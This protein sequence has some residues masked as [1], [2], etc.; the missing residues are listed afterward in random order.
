MAFF[1]EKKKHI[2]LRLN[3]REKNRMQQTNHNWN[4]GNGKI[5]VVFAC[6]S[7][8]CHVLNDNECI[9][10]QVCR[11]VCVCIATCERWNA[12]A[13]C[14]AIECKLKIYCVFT[15]A[16]EICIMEKL[17]K[18]KDY[19]EKSE[20]L[21]YPHTQTKTHIN[22]LHAQFKTIAFHFTQRYRDSYVWFCHKKCNKSWSRHVERHTTH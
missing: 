10:H 7:L 12:S 9:T 5:I 15:S 19:V 20:R 22:I 21:Q 18:I 3:R 13:Q 14:C 17:A 1:C 8:V 4:T 6:I 11:D 16:F 2:V